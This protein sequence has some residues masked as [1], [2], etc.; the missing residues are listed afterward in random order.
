M[1][2][3]GSKQL[4]ATLR[5]PGRRALRVFG[6]PERVPGLNALAIGNAVFQLEQLTKTKRVKRAV[7]PIYLSEAL[8]YDPARI[9]ELLRELV[10][11]TIVEDIDIS[12]R[13]IRLPRRRSQTPTLKERENIC[14]FSGGIDSYVGILECKEK[15]RDVL[16]VFCA[17]SDQAR[18][19]HIV[20]EIGR[21]HV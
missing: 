14:L 6:S 15:L 9:A 3:P 8:G 12:F 16:G 11:F 18:I 20:K 7:I 5:P 4:V 21:A 1:I 10:I 13:E 2:K 19:I 17:H